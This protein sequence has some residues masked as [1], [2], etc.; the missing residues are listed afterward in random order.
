MINKGEGKKKMCCAESKQHFYR[1]RYNANPEKRSMLE[2]FSLSPKQTTHK[3][4]ESCKYKEN[5]KGWWV[6][7]FKTQYRLNGTHKSNRSMVPTYNILVVY[8]KA[9]LTFPTQFETVYINCVG[10]DKIAYSETV[11]SRAFAAIH[12]TPRG[13]ACQVKQCNIALV[14]RKLVNE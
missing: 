1:R 2:Q 12:A 7:F 10:S 4:L 11:Y 8:L 13:F 9:I 3:N 6:F 5:V 14:V